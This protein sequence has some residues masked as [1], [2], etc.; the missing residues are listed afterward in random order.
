MS[1]PHE[2]NET[3]EKRE[4]DADFIDL[5]AVF[6]DYEVEGLENSQHDGGAASMVADVRQDTVVNGPTC[7]SPNRKRAGEPLEDEI[8]SSKRQQRKD[9]RMEDKDLDSKRQQR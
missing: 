2:T 1:A 5:A 4:G 9:D 3:N 6:Q 8:P 7:Y